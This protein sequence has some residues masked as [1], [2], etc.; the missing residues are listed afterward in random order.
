MASIITNSLAPFML[1]LTPLLERNRTA[2]GQ[3]IALDEVQKVAGIDP[4]R[5]IDPIKRWFM[6]EAGI[7]VQKRG[8][9]LYLMTAK[10]QAI[11]ERT[12]DVQRMRRASARSTLRAT[13]VPAGELSQTE[14]QSAEF[15]ADLLHTTTAS[16][17]GASKAIGLQ[18]TGREPRRLKNGDR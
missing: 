16:L 2:R 9:G 7:E 18:L 5:L 3:S 1:R 10:E 12:K 6:R 15:I 8:T 4:E 17:V 11:S 13:V 14:Q